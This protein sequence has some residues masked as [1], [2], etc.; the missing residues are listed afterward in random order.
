[1]LKLAGDRSRLRQE[2]IDQRSTIQ[3]QG[4]KL[5]NLRRMIVDLKKR[6]LQ[7]TTDFTIQLTSLEI[8]NKSLK[9]QLCLFTE[10]DDVVPG[11]VVVDKRKRTDSD[12]SNVDNVIVSDVP[13]PI[14]GDGKK[15][16]KRTRVTSSKKKKQ[17]VR[18]TNTRNKK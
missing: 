7:K 18:K 10:F 5:K 13:K 2:V 11:P 4:E 1:M 8:E 15:N 14:D 17:S 12:S 9:K 6:L 16:N 3:K